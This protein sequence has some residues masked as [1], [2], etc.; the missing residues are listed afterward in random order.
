MS[1]EAVTI[2]DCIDMYERK[3]LGTELGSG[4]VMG[5]TSERKRLRIALLRKREKGVM[6]PK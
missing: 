5:F 3:G 2:Q 1:W 6:A 4:R